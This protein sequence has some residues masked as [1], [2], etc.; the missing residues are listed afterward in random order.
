MTS[1]SGGSVLAADLVL[2]WE[3]YNSSSDEFTECAREILDFVRLDIRNRIIRRYSAR[4]RV[5]T[6]CHPAAMASTLARM[7]R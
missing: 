2:N 6:A 3:R 7:F 4:R 1:V 5:R